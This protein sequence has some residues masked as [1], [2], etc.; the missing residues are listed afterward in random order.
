MNFTAAQTQAINEACHAMRSGRRLFR[1]GGYAGTGKTTIMREIAARLGSM[2]V[3]AFTGKAASVLRSK[4]LSDACTMHRLMY[5]Y[6]EATDTFTRKPSLGCQFVGVDEG[7][8]VSGEL[9]SDLRSFGVPAVVIGD[10]GQL[11]PIGDD[12]RLM[13]EPD[14]VLEEIHRQAEESTIIKFASHVRH[15]RSFKRGEKGAVKI[16]GSRLFWDSIAWADILLCGFNST[17]VKAN[18]RA[19]EHRGHK[20]PVCRDER[21]MVL[22]NNRDLGVFNGMLLTVLDVRKKTSKAWECRC[23]TDDGE[24]YELPIW[25]GNL[26]QA[27]TLNLREENVDRRSIAQVDYGYAA[28][29]HKAQGSEWGRVAVIVETVKGWDV[30]RW[31]Y[32]AA[33]RAADYLRVSI[34]GEAFSQYEEAADAGAKQKA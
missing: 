23:R 19:R 26:G 17:R 13:H 18:A 33:T 21:L 34:P 7:S 16:D 28:T 2:A 31:L 30:S 24:E 8:M 15:R 3:C 6:S 4:G 32:T 22:A 9:W 14:I 12:P 20:G 11:Q 27:K 5:E 29:V 10:P 25:L 1:I